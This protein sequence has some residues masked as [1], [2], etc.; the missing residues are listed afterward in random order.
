MKCKEIKKEWKGEFDFE[1]EM[2]KGK[3]ILNEKGNIFFLYKG[4][5]TFYFNKLQCKQINRKNY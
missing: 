1:K 2:R 5:I 4:I 3:G